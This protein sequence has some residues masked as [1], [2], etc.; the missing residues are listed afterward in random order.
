MGNRILKESI[1]SSDTIEELNWMQEVFFYRLI[2]NCD[3]HGRFDAR[4]P[5]LSSR[6]FPLKTMGTAMIAEALRGLCEASLVRLYRVEGRAYGCIRSWD[7]HQTIRAAKGKYPPPPADGDDQPAN[8]DSCI[9]LKAD[10]R[11]IQSESVSI[12]EYESK[13]EYNPPTEAEAESEHNPPTVDGDVQP[14][15]DNSCIQLKADECPIQSVSESGYEYESK[16]EYNPPAEAEAEHNPPTVDGD[17]QPANENSCIQLKADECP[18]QSVSESVSVSESESISESKSEYNPPTEAKA[19]SKPRAR[20]ERREKGTEAAFRKLWQLYPRKEGRQQAFQA[21]LKAR[22]EGATDSE[23]EAGIRTYTEL[24]RLSGTELK[25]VK[26]GSTWFAG[27]CWQDD[28]AGQLKSA[29][30]DGVKRP[31]YAAERDYT[32]EELEAATCMAALLQE[33]RALE[34]QAGCAAERR[35]PE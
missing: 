35:E 27:R 13:S 5:I 7:R 6:L 21:Y 12:S 18:I 23:I 9:R 34:A 22:K 33:A 25:Y 2:V 1:C 32:E 11:P 15:N 30:R 4:L 8:E 26:H 16:S 10:E 24:L 28:Y 29:R 20:A 19:E 31:R 3:D 17:D 14:A